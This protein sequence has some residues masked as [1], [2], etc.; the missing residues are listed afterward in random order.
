MNNYK[1]FTNRKCE[2]F[3]CHNRIDKNRF[4]CL[5]CYCPAY[6]IE[7]CPGVKAGYGTIMEDGMKDCSKCFLPHK[8]ENYEMFSAILYKH[9]KE[10]GWK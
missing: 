7:D 8:P 3:P 6:A 4:N 10:N 2:Y 5:F 9:I 1:K